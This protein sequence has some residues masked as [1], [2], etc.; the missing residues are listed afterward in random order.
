MANSYGQYKSNYTEP[1]HSVLVLGPNHQIWRNCYRYQGKFQYLYTIVK[2]FDQILK[3]ILDTKLVLT[4]NYGF[5]CVLPRDEWSWWVVVICSLLNP[6][7]SSRS[8]MWVYSLDWDRK[9][10]KDGK[11]PQ[12]PP[13]NPTKTAK[14]NCRLL[15]DR[16]DCWFL[17]SLIILPI[18]NRWP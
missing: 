6:R 1:Q 2:N 16:K 13:K 12:R 17:R 10:P 14:N 8:G 18:S 9:P 3:I 15:K 5:S 11:I 4:D 7:L